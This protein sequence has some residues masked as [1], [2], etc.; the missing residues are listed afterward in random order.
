MGCEQDR[1]EIFHARFLLLVLG[2]ISR[3]RGRFLRLIG[4]SLM[5]VVKPSSRK[6][7][8]LV[9]RSGLRPKLET[10]ALSWLRRLAAVPFLGVS[11]TSMTEGHNSSSSMTIEASSRG[12]RR[13]G[14]I[15]RPRGRGGIPAQ[16]G[17][18]KEGG[19][20]APILPTEVAGAQKYGRASS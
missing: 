4:E 12:K 9:S 2:L 19:S 17:L 16:R 1:L 7:A 5:D 11:S 15:P 13:R 18:M 6:L 14:F 3:S 8:R 10:M 20:M